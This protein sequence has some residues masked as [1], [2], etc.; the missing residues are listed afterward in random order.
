MAEIGY[1]VRNIAIRVRV[2][3][4][5]I[6]Q[7]QVELSKLILSTVVGTRG[8]PLPVHNIIV[9]VEQTIPNLQRKWTRFSNNRRVYARPS[10]I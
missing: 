1:N 7:M 8:V 3:L 10:I 2:L 4:S 9:A 5:F 6:D